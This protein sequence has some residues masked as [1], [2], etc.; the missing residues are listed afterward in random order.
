M[1]YLLSIAILALVVATGCTYDVDEDLSPNCSDIENVSYSA[2]VA[3]ILSANCNSCHS[4]AGG[5]LGGIRL[6]NYDA[7]KIWVNNGRLLGAI[8]HQA[9][10]S[11]M[12]KNAAKLPACSISKIAAWINNGAPNN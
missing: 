8:K 2:E 10:F 5:N 3:L 7:V 11:A 6:D 12:P 9:G 1:K 4:P